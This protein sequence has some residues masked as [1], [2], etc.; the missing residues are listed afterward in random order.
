[1]PTQQLLFDAA[2][3]Q[4]VE[5]RECAL[6]ALRAV[7]LRQREFTASD[8]RQAMANADAPRHWEMRHMAS[9]FAEAESLG[10][11]EKT[12]VYKNC[13]F[14]NRGPRMCWRSLLAG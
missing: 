5:W 12:G 3:V 8:V 10:W 9:V 2:D 11:C 14:P 13:T 4:T 1:M 7:C 6:D